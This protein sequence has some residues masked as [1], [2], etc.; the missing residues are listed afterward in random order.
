MLIGT[1]LHLKLDIELASYN[2][3]Y[4]L[5]FIAV[6]YLFGVSFCGSSPFALSL[7]HY[8]SSR[9]G[10]RLPVAV[11]CHFPDSY[12]PGRFF[13]RKD[14]SRIVFSRMTDEMFPVCYV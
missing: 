2:N 8:L 11:Y 13:S 14:V 12:F 6:F 7:R 4:G 5:C 3:E 10:N 9:L 1:R